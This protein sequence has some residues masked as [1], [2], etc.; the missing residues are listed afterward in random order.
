MLTVAV[1]DFPHLD[2]G[3]IRRNERFVTMVNNIINKPGSS[4]PVQAKNWYE[5]KA[6][7]NFFKN[8]EVTK[9]SLQQII[10]AHG[11]SELKDLDR[12][13]IVHDMTSISYY[14]LQA[15]GLGYLDNKKGHGIMCYN[16]LAVSLEGLPLSL[17]YQQTW[18]RSESELGKAARRK[19]RD[20]EDKES[21]KWYEGIT[22]VNKVVSKVG[23]I[24]IADRAADVYELFFS[25]Y[26]QDTDLLIRACHNRKLSDGSHLWDHIA[27]KPSQ[28]VVALEIL[29]E[30]GQKRRPIEAEVRFEKVEILRPARSK[31]KYESVELTAIEV[32]QIGKI[33]DQQEGICW[34]LLTSLEVSSLA[35]V[36]KYI[37]WYT[38]RWL[39]ER[40]H[41]VLKG[42]TKIEEL[43]LKQADSLE[44]AVAVYSLAAFKIMQLVYQSREYPDVSCEIIL[45]RSQWIALYVL[46]NENNNI[47]KQPPSLSQAVKWIGRLGGHLGRKSD[48]P[49]GLKTVWR[50]YQTLC[51]AATLY[52]FLNNENL[53]KG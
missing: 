47:P 34:T 11:C 53:G 45:T 49:P 46:I 32:R 37:K 48:G 44:K 2:L 7:Y 29:D 25:A 43:Q 6:A 42:G 36:L 16:S 19:T 38:Y 22:E 51:N 15:E 9:E 4:I 23:K 20:F 31:D 52:E 17:I 41:Y 21:Y 8:Q 50:G 14:D 30:K 18:R 28:G 26:G 35:E 24:H 27:Q 39:I 33:S 40:F 13:L 12:V 1:K 5:T 3:D 10:I